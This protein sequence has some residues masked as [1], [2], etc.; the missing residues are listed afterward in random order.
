[1]TKLFRIYLGVGFTGSLPTNKDKTLYA[2][3]AKYFSGATIYPAHGLWK[4][5]PEYSTIIEI[6]DNDYYCPNQG[7]SYTSAIELLARE[8]KDQFKQES[9]LVT[10][11]DVESELL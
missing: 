3:I 1:M 4:G 6:I 8:L 2:I 7:E 10:R 11:Q 9:V 5:K